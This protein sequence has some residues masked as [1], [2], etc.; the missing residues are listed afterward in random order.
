MVKIELEPE[1]KTN[2]LREFYLLDLGNFL[3]SD[4]YGPIAIDEQLKIIIETLKKNTPTDGKQRKPWA[5]RT[6]SH[7]DFEIVEKGLL[8]LSI[9]DPNLTTD[10]GEN[11]MTIIQLNAG[12][13]VDR[14][15]H[16]VENVRLVSLMQEQLI[17]YPMHPTP[18]S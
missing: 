13:S 10:L 12:I 6:D 14:K 3:S 7:A 11:R 9:S 2:F 15:S 8:R 18:A 16:I 1:R 4:E 17:A 5:I